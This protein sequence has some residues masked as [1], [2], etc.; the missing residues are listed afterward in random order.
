[1]T[2]EQH[3]D[4]IQQS[5]NTTKRQLASIQVITALDPIPGADRI[6]VAQVLNWQCVVKKGEYKV[7][8]NVVYIEVDSKLPERPEFEFM[9]ERKFKVKTIKLKKQISQGLIMPISILP[10]EYTNN[11][12]GDVTEVLGIT[13]YVKDLENED[14]GNVDIQQQS[15]IIK[16]LMKYKFFRTIYFK[17][18]SNI[19]GGW[20]IDLAGPKTDETRIQVAASILMR[21][22]TEDWYIAEKLDGS[23]FTAF[24]YKTKS[25]LRTIKKF[26]VCSRNIWL[27]TENE[28][29][30]WA[31]AKK[32][33]LEKKL[34]R[35]NDTYSIQGEIVGPSIQKNKYKLTEHKLY[36]FNVFK[37]GVKLHLHNALQFCTDNNL[38]FVPI[39][40]MQFNPAV[41]IG[42]IDTVQKVVNHMVELSKGKSE[43][44]KCNREGIV[45]RL[46]SNP[47][48]SFKVINPEFLLE[49][50]D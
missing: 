35:Y 36:V 48:V 3:Q 32:Y 42:N 4:I 37:N 29:N 31:I 12:G 27:K 34:L 38:D 20:P 5:T 19:K 30:F 22:Y 16:Y 21:H 40:Y 46:V 7:G 15:R 9:R 23:S 10:A 45:V 13:N 50:E 1:M 33:D 24:T 49:S 25:W 41:K 43:L 39:Q 18:N 11:V 8:D 44:Y 17:M 6:E 47:D 14:G 26:G 28:S 2:T